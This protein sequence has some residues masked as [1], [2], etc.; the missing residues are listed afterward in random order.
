M[1]VK[2]GINGFGR[3]GRNILRAARQQN[4]DIEF[5]AVN[6]ITTPATLAHLLKYDT[7]LGRFPGTVS[8]DGDSIV[9]DG[10]RIKVLAEREPAN[11]PWR[12]LG[13]D[14]VIESTGKFTD[15]TKARAHIDGG[16]RKVIISA[17]A[18]NEDLTV[19]MGVNEK[20]YDPAVHH[21]LSN[22]SCT[23]NCLA[24]VAKVLSD[25]FGI[26]SGF[27]TTVHSYT[28]DQLVL[29]GP[30]KDLRRARAAALAII[31]TSSGAA[32]ALH[33]VLPQLKG[34]LTG[35]ALRVPTPDV[36]LVDL[37]VILEKAASAEEINAAFSK[38]AEGELKGILGVTDEPL[39]S[40][41]FLHE[42]NSAVVD[43]LSTMV[44]GES[45]VKVL[46]WYDNEWGYSCRTVD[47]VEYVAKRL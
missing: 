27:M 44:I 26:E 43:L 31:P 16:A 32:K 25:S 24:P 39:V 6:D 4:A 12:D 35:F 2:V 19:V 30:H 42:N 20:A 5:V 47:L 9:V 37:T 45:H 22:A 38:A 40:A 1:A 15:A 11:L 28:N 14:V 36:S 10:K 21:I 17:P 18:K 7:I 13:A 46:A 3:I 8:V 41:D 29:D 23:T 34:K 33:L